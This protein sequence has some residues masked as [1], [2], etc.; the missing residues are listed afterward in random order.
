MPRRRRKAPKSSA[1]IQPQLVQGPVTI[2]R[3]AHGG[4][5]VG[6]LDGLAVF[7]PRTAPGD[8]AEIRL[9]DQRRRYAF[10]EL[11]TLHDTSPWR[12]PPPCPYYDDCG[13]C[14]LQHLSYERQLALKRE[15]VGDSLTRIGKLTEVPVAPTLSSPHALGYRNKVLYHYDR[16]HKHLGLVSRH[17]GHILDLQTCLISDTRADVVMAKIRELAVAQ[18]A[19]HSVLHQVQVQVGQRTAE[20]LVT[21]IVE[22]APPSSIQQT[23]WAHIQDLATGLWMHV[24]TQESPAVFN[25]TSSLIAGA[26]AIHERIGPYRF[27]IEPQAFVQ[28]NS[29]QMEQLYQWVQ[30]V[31]ELE[32]REIILDLYSGSGALALLLAPRC[33]QVYAVEI[34][35]QA[36]LIAEQQAS[37]LDIQNC[38]FRTGKV[39]RILFRYIA[40]GIKADL[41]ILD[42]PRAGCRPDALNALAMMRVPR[43][44]YISCSPPTL[45][46]DLAL[47]HRLGYQTTGV[48]PF[49][50]FPQTYHIECVATLRRTG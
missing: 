9:V 41:A 21:V 17:S 38:E 13:G 1:P 35:R 24:K 16:Q 34:N 49:D 26:E 25:G 10:G 33:R 29:A 31:S 15:Q 47:L 7:V 36:S 43:L 12:V 19:L 20:V 22:A 6:Y 32:G 11:V 5:G 2:E 4:Y 50:M 27:R 37:Q 18:P 23:L 14:H 45:A 30:D 3:F 39:E 40:Q 44:I 48:Q 28:V 46:R 42:P 8:V